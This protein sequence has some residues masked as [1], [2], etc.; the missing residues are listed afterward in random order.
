MSSATTDEQLI[1]T[2]MDR[3]RNKGLQLTGEGGMLQQLTWRVLGVVTEHVGCENTI[4][5]GGLQPRLAHGRERL[6]VGGL[7]FSGSPAA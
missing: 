7:A 1:A 3:A 6:L 5:P 2:L 4:Q